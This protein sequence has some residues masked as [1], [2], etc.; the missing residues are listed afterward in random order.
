MWFNLGE[1]IVDRH[2]YDI[3]QLVGLTEVS[4]QRFCIRQSLGSILNEIC[5]WCKLARQASSNRCVRF[6]MQL[7]KAGKAK[8]PLIDL[9][10]ILQFCRSTQ[11]QCAPPRCWACRIIAQCTVALTSGPEF[12]MHAAT[13]CVIVVLE[14]QSF[15]CCEHLEIS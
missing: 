3:V 10:V 12:A 6:C 1:L 13:D 9:L 14:Q 8:T 15:K 5:Q 2:T 11:D 4:S 7:K